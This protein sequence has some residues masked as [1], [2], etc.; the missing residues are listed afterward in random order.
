MKLYLVRHGEAVQA[1][2]DRERVL[3]AMGRQRVA[4]TAAFLQDNDI[5][6]EIIYHSGKTRA[7]ETARIIAGAIN[8][9]RG[10][11]EAKGLGPNDPINPW[12]EKSSRFKYDTMIVGHL[13]YLS[14]FASLLLTGSE[15]RDIFKIFDASVI[16]LEYS[17]GW[18][19]LW[20]VT[21]DII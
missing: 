10:L 12:A 13:P 4:K 14:K 16:C 1:E 20:F 17:G 8:P 11:E 18:S 5:T 21:P 9:L 6:A 15:D 3:T 2:A 19:V 7:L